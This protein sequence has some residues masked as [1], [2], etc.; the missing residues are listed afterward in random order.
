MVLGSRQRSGERLAD[1]ADDV[2]A[3][4]TSIIAI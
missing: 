1:F 4:A 2:A 3:T